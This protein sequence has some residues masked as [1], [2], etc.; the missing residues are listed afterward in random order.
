[1]VGDSGAFAWCVHVGH[2]RDD[3]I[4]GADLVLEAGIDSAVS[5]A[6][7][8]YVILDYAVRAQRGLRPPSALV[9]TRPVSATWTI[10]VDTRSTIHP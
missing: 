1:M 2:A 10:D 3:E 8:Q 6:L 4:L 9:R 7:W 5:I